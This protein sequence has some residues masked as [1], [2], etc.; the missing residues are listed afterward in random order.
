[1]K[2]Y[3]CLFLSGLFFGGTIDHVVF[4]LINSP[5]PYGIKLGLQGNLLMAFFDLLIASTLLLI[6]KRKV[7]T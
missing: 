4:A 2:W 3:I 1:M 5:A 6:F 7:T